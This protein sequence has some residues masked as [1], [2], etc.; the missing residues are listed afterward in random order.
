LWK[1]HYIEDPIK[2]VMVVRVAGLNV[3]LATVKDW[4]GRHQFGKDAPDC[5]DI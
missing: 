5:P 2:L 3:L 4:F 1:A